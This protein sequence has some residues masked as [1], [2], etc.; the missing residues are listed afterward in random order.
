MGAKKSQR[1]RRPCALAVASAAATAALAPPFMRQALAADRTWLNPVNGLYS[2]PTKWSGGVVPGSSDNVRLNQSGSYTITFAT[3]PGAQQLLISAGTVTL[4]LA[5]HS[6]A[7][8]STT[9]QSILLGTD[10]TFPASPV[11]LTVSNGLFSGRGVTVGSGFFGPTQ[12]TLNNVLWLNTDIEVGGGGL[13]SVTIN[14][15]SELRTQ[16]NIFGNGASGRITVNSGGL[17]S[18][19]STTTDTI[20][21]NQAIVTGTVDI[22]A[23]GQWVASGGVR[24]GSSG[25]GVINIANDGTMSCPSMY[26]GIGLGGSGTLTVNGATSHRGSF[27]ASQSVYVG[28]SASTAGGSGRLIVNSGI[29]TIANQLKLWNTGT[30]QLSDGS[31]T[32]ASINYSAG[33]AI[34]WTAG[35]LRLNGASGLTLTSG[36]LPI[37]P[38]TSAKQLIVDQT[39]TIGAGR[40]VDLNGG[41]L[42]VGSLQFAGGGTLNWPGGHLW[43]T[44]SSVDV[45]PG[46]LFGPNLTV[47]PAQSFT[48]GDADISGPVLNVGTAAGA[49]TLTVQSLDEVRGEMNVGVGGG[50]GYILCDGG[51]ATGVNV[52]GDDGTGTVL[53]QSGLVSPE[54]VAHMGVFAGGAGTLL[55]DGASSNWRSSGLMSGQFIV[56]RAG[57]G[58]VRITNGARGQQGL[59]QL[60][61]GQ[62]VGGSGTLIVEG[63]GSY[64]RLG[65]VSLTPPA[66]GTLIV[67][68]AGSGSVLITSNGLLQDRAA[69]IGSSASGT[70]VVTIGGN[71]GAGTWTNVGTLVVGAAGSGSLNVATNGFVQAARLF[72]GSGTNGFGSVSLVGTGAKLQST[73]SIDLGTSAFA[74][75]GF[76]HAGPGAVL[77]SG[78]TL[79]V[80]SGSTFSYGGAVITS[81]NLALR[82]GTMTGTG[83]YFAPIS[84]LNGSI[85]VPDGATLSLPIVP[86]VVNLSASTVAKR[87]NGTL[88]LAGV[89]Q[90]SGAGTVLVSSGTLNIA[91]DL[92]PSISAVVNGPAATANFEATQHLPRLTVNDGRAALTAG[93]N[94]VLVT[95]SLSID[96]SDARLD[97]A[98]NDFVLD[99]TGATQYPMISS[100]I[101]TARNGG[102]WNGPG[103][104]TS[105]AAAS[106]SSHNTTLGA[107]NSA[108]FF[109]IYGGGA[110]FDGQT[111]DSTAVLVKYTFYGDSDFNGRVNFDDYVRIDNG[112]N[113]HL[114]DWVN[115][116][117]DLN[118]VVNF[119]D[120]VLID[121]AFNTQS[122]TLRRALRFLDGSDRSISMTE[123][124]LRQVRDHLQHFGNP[125]ARALIAAVPEPASLAGVIMSLFLLPRRARR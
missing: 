118:G 98:D 125:Y 115:G 11:N 18:T 48:V 103:G 124:P 82:S 96:A 55:V 63:T 106:N 78:G 120:Y 26:L 116:D 24:L 4:D 20:V 57:S 80:F 47:T 33:G 12:V 2:D 70:G 83:T 92:G 13:G 43:I 49:G 21:G 1:C 67:G 91:S 69:V 53:V 121:L 88:A 112:F 86:S 15:G 44:A 60:E 105:S 100:L 32:C 75:T 45:A 73:G 77:D 87:G 72:V 119:D 9:S 62:L 7:L 111:I 61:L 108:D 66:D 40:Q 59:T 102:A 41:S 46:G 25:M 8:M 95:S 51:Q 34:N 99:Y 42:I 97:L 89:L 3:S 52:I 104:I 35:S 16:N 5:N 38:L 122:G 84:N 19:T 76:L 14:T 123:L 79:T 58:F 36:G 50:A 110:M 28:G 71:A 56:G 22:N 74:S 54:G 17:L 39:L 10:T 114:G 81:T 94:K 27:V 31:L 65:P 117:F 85:E 6:Y 68:K 23:D 37:S 29:V 113:N 93:G 30:V 101:S 109:S 90:A 64:Y 107:M